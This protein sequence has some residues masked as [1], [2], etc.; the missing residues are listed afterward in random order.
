MLASFIAFMVV[1]VPLPQFLPPY[2]IATITAISPCYCILG[3]VE[4]RNGIKEKTTVV[5]G[6]MSLGLK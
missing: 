3:I 1:V 6:N 5:V 4:I 2:I